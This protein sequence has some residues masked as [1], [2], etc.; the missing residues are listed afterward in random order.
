MSVK[1]A[2]IVERDQFRMLLAEVGKGMHP[3]R[4]EVA[5]RLS[6]FAGLRACEIANLRWDNNVLTAGGKVG[7]AIHITS[8]VGKRSVERFI[9]LDPELKKALA[10]LRKER[11]K[12]EFVF[13]AIHNNVKVVDKWTRAPL[14]QIGQVTP[15]AVVQWFKRLYA[16]VGLQGCTSHSGRR[17]FITA[18]ARV[19]NLQ[20]C[21]I[22]DVMKLAGHK[23]LQTTQDYVEPSPLQHKLVSAWG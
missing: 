1:R 5:L 3:L 4:D 9:P 14:T 2:K 19:A 6:F 15:N 18:R 21:S 17:T 7:N 23:S 12:D 16:S 10:A 22:V 11:P 20:G 8:D 13:Y